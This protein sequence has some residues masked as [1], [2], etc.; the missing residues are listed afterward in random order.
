MSA[1]M[2][3][4]VHVLLFRFSRF[5][6]ACG[7]EPHPHPRPPLP[8]DFLAGVA[9]L[10]PTPMILNDAADDGEAESGAL[11]ARLNVRLEQPAAILLRQTNAVIDDIDQN[12]VV[13][14]R[15]TDAERALA[16]P[17]WRHPRDGRGRSVVII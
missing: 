5:G 10:D 6:V 2:S 14:A 15:A 9:Q 7:R 4:P 3:L 17:R 8:R 11:L 1:D 16:E 12:V 13:F